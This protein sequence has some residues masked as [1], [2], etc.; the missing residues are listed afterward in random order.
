MKLNTGVVKVYD[1]RM[2]MKEEN[3]IPKKQGRYLFV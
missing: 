1:S 3:P 2:C